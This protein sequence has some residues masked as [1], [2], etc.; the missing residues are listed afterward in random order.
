MA[1]SG[2]QTK[3]V[4]R[5]MSP[6]TGACICAHMIST[7]SARD[8]ALLQLEVPVSFLDSM[9]EVGNIASSPVWRWYTDVSR[10]RER[11]SPA[12]P[13]SSSAAVLERRWCQC[14]CQRHPRPI[15]PSGR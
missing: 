1:F 8:S 15:C 13:R 14:V 3:G 7:S 9:F 2:P 12:R 11:C 10:I 6:G 4:V 5:A